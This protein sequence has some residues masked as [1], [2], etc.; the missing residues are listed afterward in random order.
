MEET[1]VLLGVRWSPF[2]TNKLPIE[3]LLHVIEGKK[4]RSRFKQLLSKSHGVY[5]WWVFLAT[6]GKLHWLLTVGIT[7][8]PFPLITTKIQSIP[9]NSAV[10][11]VG[12][13]HLSTCAVLTSGAS[14]MWPF[15]YLL[16]KTKWDL[17]SGHTPQLL[18]APSVL[19][20]FAVIFFF[21]SC[22]ALFI[23]II[24]VEYMLT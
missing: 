8:L 16:E 2:S 10:D 18:S 24:A 21:S 15:F 6:F 20:A 11:Q 22:A 12:Y 7:V 19:I 9:M 17:T 13:Y 5:H 14:R 3:Q 4:I 1:Q 23:M